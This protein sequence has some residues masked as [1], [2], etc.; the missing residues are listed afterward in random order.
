MEK[1]IELLN[2]YEKETKKSEY[3]EWRGLLWGRPQYLRCD[4][5]ESELLI[6]SKGYHFIKW[7]VENEKIEWEKVYENLKDYEV[8]IRIRAVK[9]LQLSSEKKSLWY[10]EL[11]MLLSIQDEPIEFLVSILK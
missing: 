4:T 8:E 2:K 3:S 1:L 7:L 6:I 5:V 9:K 11:L 10:L